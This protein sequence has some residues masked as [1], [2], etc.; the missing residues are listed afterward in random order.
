MI[1]ARLFDAD[2]DLVARYTTPRNGDTVVVDIDGEHPFKVWKRQ[3]P[4]VSLH[5]PHLFEG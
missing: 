1:M 4:R 2:I 3:G 5:V